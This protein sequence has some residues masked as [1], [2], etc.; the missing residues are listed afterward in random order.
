V[1]VQVRVLRNAKYAT[2]YYHDYLPIPMDKRCCLNNAFSPSPAPRPP[3]RSSAVTVIRTKVPTPI[4]VVA[5]LSTVNWGFYGCAVLEYAARSIIQCH[6][7]TL[8]GKIIAGH[9]DNFITLRACVCREINAIYRRCVEK[10]NRGQGKD[11]FPFY[12][13]RVFV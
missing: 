6:I 1:K 5:V 11:G 4:Y 7:Y 10:I 13:G 12:P 2:N 3:G 9:I 8:Y